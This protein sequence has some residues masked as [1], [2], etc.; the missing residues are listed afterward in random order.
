[1]SN[2]YNLAP[3]EICLSYWSDKEVLGKSAWEAALV[4]EEMKRTAC[5]SGGARRDTPD[6]RD[7]RIAFDAII[8]PPID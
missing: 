2:S 6:K 8:T 1:L 3:P 7:F 5:N 4:F